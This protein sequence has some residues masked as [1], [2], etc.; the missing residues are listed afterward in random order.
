MVLEGLSFDR[1]PSELQTFFF[2]A[3]LDLISSFC[4]VCQL[5]CSLAST[6][7]VSVFVFFCFCFCF[8]PVS[9]ALF[10]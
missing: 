6:V 7:L 10:F 1:N 5:K 2:R 8:G 4:F 3:Y 9:K